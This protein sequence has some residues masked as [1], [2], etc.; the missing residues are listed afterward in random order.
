MS[1]WTEIKELHK[2]S[3][4]GAKEGVAFRYFSRPI[5][6]FILYHIQYGKITPN[7]VTILS[8][9]TGIVGT[10][11]HA[12][13]LSWGGLVA[14]GAAFMM[15]HMLDAL[16]GQLARHRKAG[17][18]IGMHFDFFIDGIKAFLMYGALSVRLYRQAAHGGGDAPWGGDLSSPLLLL[19]PLLDFGGPAII[20]LAAV[21]GMIA[22][23]TGVA[24]TDFMKKKEWKDLVSPPGPDG[25]SA[26][27]PKPGSGGGVVGMIF[28]LGH[29]VVDY[30][31]YILILC[32]ANR[33]DAYLLG[34]TVVVA[35]YAC[36]AM[37]G[38][39]LRLWRINPY[40]PK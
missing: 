30:P 14:G 34:Y 31:S 25:V 39:M 9:L 15:A 4:A 2:K 40:A 36:Q 33:V 11:I 12:T 16:D 27:P 6:S 18:V 26:P 5:A 29:F 32:F 8:L 28:G 10:V 38:I 35:A 24:C 22:L 19:R 7:Q 13:W 3:T 1:A 23:A 17:S 21:V 20:P 37:A